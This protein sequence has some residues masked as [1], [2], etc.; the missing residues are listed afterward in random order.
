LRQAEEVVTQYLHLCEQR[1]LEDAAH[2]LLP[3][4]V[5]IFPG[6]RVFR[7]LDE[8][9]E[10]SAQRYVSLTKTRQRTW[11]ATS[12]D[13]IQVVTSGLL[14]GV[15]RIGRVFSDVRFIDVFALRGL[16]IATQE[17]WNDLAEAGIVAPTEEGTQ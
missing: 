17:V 2:F 5:L 7:S 9:V 13:E 10:F 11:S 1:R 4:A 15:S 8:M 12:G 6:G 16:R 3:E 14:N